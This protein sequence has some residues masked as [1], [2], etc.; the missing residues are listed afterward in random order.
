[1]DD[2]DMVNVPLARSRRADVAI[3]AGL[4]VQRGAAHNHFTAADLPADVEV[5]GA[6][7]F[8]ERAAGNIDFVQIVISAAHADKDLVL[9]GQCAAGVDLQIT[10]RT[11]GVKAAD[12][13]LVSVRHLPRMMAGV[14]LGLTTS[15]ST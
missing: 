10:G 14:L 5:A 1:M 2:P 9:N 7:R 12:A 3:G 6:G 4:V 15:M 13:Q 8:R 11:T